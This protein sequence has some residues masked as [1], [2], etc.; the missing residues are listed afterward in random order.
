MKKLHVG[1]VV[2]ANSASLI[3]PEQVQVSLAEIAGQAREGLLAL[4][5][6][7]GLAVLQETMEW[8]VEQVTGP[9]GRHD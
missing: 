8:E 4:A 9:K 7:A 3:L 1:E 5:V 2:E 6:S